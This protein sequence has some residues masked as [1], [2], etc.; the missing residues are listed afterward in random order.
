[1]GINPRSLPL[2]TLEKI[3]DTLYGLTDAQRRILE[4][5]WQAATSYGERQPLTTVEELIQ[6]G[7]RGGQTRRAAR[8]RRRDGSTG[9]RG[10]SEVPLLH[11]P[12]LFNTRYGDTY[13]GEPLKLI[14]PH[15]YL[16]TP[17]IHIFD[18]SGLDNL[19]QQIFLAVLLDQLYRVSTQRKNFT[20]LIVIE[21][22]HNFAPATARRRQQKLR[23]ENSQR[24][25]K[26]RAGL[27]LIT[28]RPAKL[29]Q[30][31]ASQAMT[32]IFKRMINPNDLKYVT[33][34]AEHLDDPR[35]LRTLDETEALITGVSVPAPLL[36][37][38]DQR[39]TH[40]GGT[41]PKLIKEER[42]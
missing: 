9:L 12:D 3:L 40:H 29:D 17:A 5:G 13:N 36:I 41:T 38:V 4:E 30:D 42:D 7:Y 16:T 37:T 34:V 27:C 1:V 14:D 22:A 2:R 26:I 24:R 21:E 11:K 31:V 6:R 19:D 18:V 28:Q 33:S 25:Q 32:Q 10:P 39:W 15:A 35:P 20:T 23:R 8:L